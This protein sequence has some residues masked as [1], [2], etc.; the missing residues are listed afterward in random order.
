MEEKT[1]KVN[2]EN[3]LSFQGG[4][5]PNLLLLPSAGGRGKEYSL[6]FPLLIPHFTVFSLDYPG[7][8]K[9]EEIEQIE[10]VESLAG[11]ILSWME[12]LELKKVF[13]TGF[14]MGGAVAM[15]M[16]LKKPEVIQKLCLIATAAGNNEKVKIISPV[17]MGLKE[18]LNKFYFRPEVKELIERKKLSPE[19]KREIHRS[20]RAFA[21]LAERKR[22]FVDI[23]DRLGAIQIPTLVIGAAEDQAVPVPF[24]EAIF[25]ALPNARL[26]VYPETGHFVIIER[27]QEVACDLIDYFQ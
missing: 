18:I 24:Q 16:A 19:D 1:V 11:F 7:F 27:A 3:I 13:L 20:S 14:S 17:G 26:K 4:R 25:K 5:G 15:H 12:T 21:R 22:V 10:G 23:L 8:G 6:L 2:G 9:S